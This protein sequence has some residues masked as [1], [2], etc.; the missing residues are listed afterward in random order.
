MKQKYSPILVGR[1]IT[2]ADENDKIEVD[3]FSIFYGDLELIPKEG[4][5]VI[6]G[7]ED[8]FPTKAGEYDVMMTA[9][10]LERLK[11]E[12]PDYELAVSVLRKGMA[13]FQI[14]G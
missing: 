6:A 2:S 1:Q 8:D 9:Q 11:K 4:E 13:T 10:L 3:N 12:Y 14:T 5:L 7:Y